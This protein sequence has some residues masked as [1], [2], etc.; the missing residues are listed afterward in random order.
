MVIDLATPYPG[1]Y[2]IRKMAVY[3]GLLYVGFADGIS[4]VS[5]PV[6]DGASWTT[7]LTIPGY[8][9]AEMTPTGGSLW[10]RGCNQHTYAYDHGVWHDTG[11]AP[12]PVLDFAEYNGYIYAATYGAG[13]IYRQA[14]TGA[15]GYSVS[16]AIVDSGG[17]PLPGV[18]VSVGSASALTDAGG[19]YTITGI[20]AGDY[21]LTP[22]KTGYAFNPTSRPVSVGPDATG[23]NFIA[24]SSASNYSISG[25]VIAAAN[26]TAM[27]GVI[28]SDGNGHTATT[29]SDGT[30]ILG[31]L[32]TGTYTIT[33]S[34]DGFYFD[35]FN[36]SIMIS[37]D[38]S[39]Q[40]FTGFINAG[41]VLNAN[42]G[43]Q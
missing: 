38:A 3:N 30:Y 19:N 22:S 16:G 15:V 27:P 23:L 28:I 20:P 11:S 31:G 17:A 39:G 43:F 32:I 13:K 24:V 9:T 26:S 41:L 25:R 40:D 10:A 21:T 35:P 12:D 8:T 2:G 18:S 29:S 14:M 1:S 6:Y 7:S 33:P 42:S 37:S 36:R 34:K 5:I 4:P